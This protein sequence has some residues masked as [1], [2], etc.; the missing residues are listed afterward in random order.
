MAEVQAYRLEVI[1]VEFWLR[2]HVYW[3]LNNQ[4]MK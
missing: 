1:E 3:A 2:Y 4:W